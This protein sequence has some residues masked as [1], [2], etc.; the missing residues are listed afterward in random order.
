MPVEHSPVVPPPRRETRSAAAKRQAEPASTS[1]RRRESSWLHEDGTPYSTRDTPSLDLYASPP[2]RQARHSSRDSISVRHVSV[3]ADSV[4]SHAIYSPAAETA[5]PSVAADAFADKEIADDSLQRINSL[6][7]EVDEQLVRMTDAAAASDGTSNCAAPPTPKTIETLLSEATAIKYVYEDDFKNVVPANMTL[8]GMADVVQESGDLR[9]R[10]TSIIESLLVLKASD[11]DIQSV[12]DIKQCIVVVWKH[13]QKCSV[14]RL[15]QQSATGGGAAMPAVT[16]GHGA[17]GAAPPSTTGGGAAMPAAAD[18]QGAAGAN[19]AFKHSTTGGG[20]PDSAVAAS[21]AAARGHEA[22]TGGEPPLIIIDDDTRAAASK[23]AAYQVKTSRVGNHETVLSLEIDALITELSALATARPANNRGILTAEATRVEL[24]RK[25]ETLVKEATDLCKDAIDVGQARAALNLDGKARELSSTMRD[26]NTRLAELKIDANLTG[27]KNA[28]PAA[29]PPPKFG[30]LVSDDYFDFIEKYE[31]YVDSQNFSTL[32]QLKTL[33]ETCLTGVVRAACEPMTSE[34]EVLRYIKGLYGLPR[35]LLD[36][37]LKEFK[38]LGK[39]PGTPAQ[40]RRDWL[41]LAV[42]QMDTLLRICTKHRLLSPLYHSNVAQEFYVALPYTLQRDYL[43]RIALVGGNNEMDAEEEQFNEMLAFGKELIT[44]ATSDVRTGLILGLKE[45]KKAVEKPKQPPIAKKVSGNAA[46]AQSAHLADDNKYKPSRFTG[47]GF[48]RRRQISAAS[49]E[50]DLAAF[51]AATQTQ[52]DLIDCKL[53]KGAHTHV[54]YCPVFQKTL[55][56]ERFPIT[57]AVCACMRCL[58]MDSGLD[59]T[60]RATWWLGHEQYCDTEWTCQV[61]WCGKTAK[62]RQMH[63]TMCARHTRE[64]RTRQADFIATLE[65]SQVSDTTRFFFNDMIFATS[66][67]L[68]PPEPARFAEEVEVVEGSDEPAIYM[69]QDVPGDNGEKLLLFFDSGCSQAAISQRAAACIENEVIVPG[70]MKMGVAGGKVID[71]DDGINKFW[72]QTAK[73]N[74]VVSMKGMVMPEITTPL[75]IY[76]LQAA[77]DT[78]TSWAEN[79]LEVGIDIPTVPDK[80]GGQNVD[81]MVGIRYSAWFPE[82]ILQLPSGLAIYETKLRSASGCRGVLGGPHESWRE[83]AYKAGIMSNLMFINSEIRAVRFNDLCLKSTFP[84]LVS[85]EPWEES[86]DVPAF[87]TEEI[88]F[89]SMSARFPGE[90]LDPDWCEAEHCSKHQAELWKIPQHWNV[91]HFV[92]NHRAAVDR[93]E[94]LESLGSEITYRCVKCRNCASCRNGEFFERT[95]LAEEAE[96]ALIEECVWLDPKK[97]LLQCRLPF[98]RDP[99]LALARNRT[100]VEQ[101]L[102]GQMRSIVRNPAVMTSIMAAHDKLY[103]KGHVAAYNELSDVEKMAVDTAKGSYFIPWTC[104]FKEGSVSTPYRIVFN[105]SH[106]T[107]TGESLNSVLAKGMNKLPRILNL[108]IR[109][110]SRKEALTGD[111]SMAYNNLKIIPDHYTYQRYLWYKDLDLNN[112]VSE[113]FIKTMIYGVKAAGGACAAGFAHVADYALQH[114]PEHAAA[115]RAVKEDTYVDDAAVSVSTKAEAKHLAESMSFVLGLGG[116]SV[117]AFSFSGQPPAE[118]VSA[119]G[120][121]LGVLGY[122]WKPVSDTI[123]LTIKDLYLGKAKKGKT[124]PPVTGCLKTALSS[125]FTKRTLAGKV[126]GVYDPKG[127]ATPITAKLKLDLAEVNDL[128]VDWDDPVPARLLDT[129]VKNLRDIQE[130]RDISFPRSFIYPTATTEDIELIISVDASQH[131]AVAT[132]HARTQGGDGK[133]HCRLICARSKLVHLSTVPKG[134]LRAA[135]MGAS[136]GHVVKQNIPGRIKRVVYVTD[137]TIVLF[138]INQDSRPLQTGVRNSSL[139][140]RRL[141]DLNDWRHVESAGN[142]ADIGTRPADP[143]SIGGR[144]EWAEGKPWMTLPW[145]E[146]PLRSISDIKLSQ[147]EMKEAKREIRA[148]DFCGYVLPAITTKVASRFDYSKYL[149]EPTLMSWEKSVRVLAFVRRFILKISKRQ[150]KSSLLAREHCLEDV[151]DQ[152][153][154]PD[155]LNT[156]NQPDLLAATSREESKLPLPLTP[157]KVTDNIPGRRRGFELPDSM[158]KPDQLFSV[159]TC[160]S[161]HDIE[162]CEDYFFRKATKEVLQFSKAADFKHCSVMKDKILTYTGRIMDGQCIDDV[163]NIMGDLQPL[164]F[165]KPLVDRHSPVAYAV[166][167]YVHNKVTCHRNPVVTLNASRNICYILHG[168]ELANEIAAAC[169][170]CRRYKAKVLA[171]EM[172]KQHPARLTVAPAFY[173]CQ[174]DLA[175][176][177]FARCEHNHRSRVKVWAVVFKDPSSAAVAIYAMQDSTAAAFIQ[178]YNRHSY[179]YGHPKKLFVDAGSQLLK[180]CRKGEISWTDITTSLTRQSGVGIEHEVC[181]PN[182]HYMH[183]CVERSIKEVKAILVKVFSTFT[184][185]LFGFETAFAF[186]ANELNCLPLS[187]GSKSDNLGSTD[188]ITPSRLLLGRNNRRAPTGLATVCSASQTLE[189]LAL[190]HRAWW[191]AWMDECLVDHVPQPKKWT[192]GND[193]IKK[194]DVVVFVKTEDEGIGDT[195]WRIGKVDSVIGSRDGVARKVVIRYK[196]SPEDQRYRKV[197]RGLREVAVLHR[198]GE[199]ELAEQLNAAAKYVAK[200]FW[201]DLIK[202]QATDP[203]YKPPDWSVFPLLDS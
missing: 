68:N 57:H 62:A 117:K 129:W 90:S 23:N 103:L 185:S 144:S 102:K 65:P 176:P 98:I 16:G 187:L 188:L 119:D 67:E 174:V 139:E 123:S 111:V 110:G 126:A 172:G 148:G 106:R 101:I 24:A 33:K 150:F 170:Y 195:T 46:A 175:G 202:Q 50:E 124:P 92:Y 29:V 192:K 55:V 168:R 180:A 18:G 80:I 136:L 99:V 13:I 173:N 137:S 121:S 127:Y 120:E 186:A 177:F 132:A 179:R 160:L 159:L 38:K 191:K 100:Q 151:P 128:K 44:R 87:V 154:T 130:L 26:C 85:E 48:T 31:A 4:L 189:D 113:M 15:A 196:L 83:A 2:L 45:D 64:N 178:C 115:A 107:K 198:E 201:M 157:T 197:E 74:Q 53:C 140:V 17:A 79:N 86:D 133:F 161:Q 71:L 82:L 114:H 77:F 143:G 52:P 142:V 75:R 5:G 152:S 76:Q 200:S 145:D 70:P 34:A 32:D 169:T 36:N 66:F 105:A 147:E 60:D 30:G 41:I 78:I 39:C 138:W 63:F 54:F 49:S 27:A 149:V 25:A 184:M 40:E 158:T 93:Y 42:N 1:A 47:A 9:R 109:F 56:K 43:N 146:M 51:P 182:A 194:D 165:A 183:G 199:L 112:E 153:A 108:L 8:E 104:V 28:S 203:S 163:E 6:V 89:T 193:L 164:N 69:L 141:T 162:V 3:G 156:L 134:E 135:V 125:T 35:T 20:E 116:M 10:L 97:H 11:D 19:F 58:R 88:L 167:I 181:P 171:I 84:E 166:M 22:T 81:I 131:I 72:L 14:E 94:N 61:E 96:Q 122:V 12:R 155:N 118:E 190:I 91:D 37:K 59:L 7:S 73:G 95:S 21:H